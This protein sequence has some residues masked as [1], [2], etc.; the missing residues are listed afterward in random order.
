MQQVVRLLLATI[1]AASL[2]G[3]LYA[4]GVG[5]GSVTGIVTD[6]AGGVVPGVE[7]SLRNVATSVASVVVTNAEGNYVLPNLIPGTYELTPN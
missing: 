1:V 6:A 2:C 3:A 4:Q 5:T 7:I